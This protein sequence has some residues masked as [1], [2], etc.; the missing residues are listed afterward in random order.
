MLFNIYIY[1]YLYIYIYKG[2]R[3][4]SRYCSCQDSEFRSAMGTLSVDIDKLL[5]KN[6]FLWYSPIDYWCMKEDVPHYVLQP[7]SD[8]IAVVTMFLGLGVFRKGVADR[9]YHPWKYHR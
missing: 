4:L 9:H 1:I 3:I 2:L 5:S 7:E 6:F 8:E